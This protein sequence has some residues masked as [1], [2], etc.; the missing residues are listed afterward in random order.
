MMSRSWDYISFSLCL[1]PWGFFI[2]YFN[3]IDSSDSKNVCCSI[4]DEGLSCYGVY[5]LTSDLSLL[6]GRYWSKVENGQHTFHFLPTPR[7][8]WYSFSITV[9]ALPI[10]EFSSG[11]SDSFTSHMR[12]VLFLQWLTLLRYE[13]S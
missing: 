13:V 12:T 4:F 5:V 11:L 3:W 1:F 9:A 10:Q 7:I 2:G 6:L 8:Q